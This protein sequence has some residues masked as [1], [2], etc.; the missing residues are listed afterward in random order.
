[1]RVVHVDAHS[2]IWYPR[3]PRWMKVTAKPC[4]FLSAPGGGRDALA[5]TDLPDEPRAMSE[6]GRTTPPRAVAASST[7]ATTRS[8]RGIGCETGEGS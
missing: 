6:R 2:V 5:E 3:R 8:S 1:L 4:L 7:G